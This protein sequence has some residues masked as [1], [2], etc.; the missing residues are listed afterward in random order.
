MLGCNCKSDLEDVCWDFGIDGTQ[1]WFLNHWSDT[2]R[3]SSVFWKLFAACENRI[4]AILA[5]HLDPLS[6]A[7]L[8][9]LWTHGGIWDLGNAFF[10]N[11]CLHLTNSRGEDSKG[12]SQWKKYSIIRSSMAFKALLLPSSHSLPRK[13]L[14]L[15]HHPVPYPLR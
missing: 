12:I 1:S 10:L 11:I 4:S 14:W 15:L 6:F 3:S 5:S 7:V 2:M 13:T 8:T 9:S